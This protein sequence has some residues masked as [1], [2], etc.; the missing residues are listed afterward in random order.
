MDES[1][2]IKFLFV[3]IALNVRRKT[4]WREV[5]TVSKDQLGGCPRWGMMVICSSEESKDMEKMV[6]AQ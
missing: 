6:P 4:D 5:A 2:R 1:K 3:K